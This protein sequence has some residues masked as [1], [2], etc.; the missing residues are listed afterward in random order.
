LPLL[1]QLKAGGDG[2][3]VGK[4]ALFQSLMR[5]TKDFDG[6]ISRENLGGVA[7]VPLTG[8]FGQSF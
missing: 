2:G 7:F 1:E 8:E 6:N 4:V 5:I 3:S